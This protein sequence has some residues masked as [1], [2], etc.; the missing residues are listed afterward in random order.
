MPL[1][2]E[3]KDRRYGAR[4]HANQDIFLAAQSGEMIGILGPNWAGKNTLAPHP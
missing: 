3:R 1:S 2:V 4:V